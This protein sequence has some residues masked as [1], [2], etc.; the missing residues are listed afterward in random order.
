MPANGTDPVH[1]GAAERWGGWSWRGPRRG[2]HWRTCSYCGSIHPE[3]LAVEIQGENPPRPEWSDFKY[4]W[5]HK[6]YVR[7]IALR[8]TDMLRVFSFGNHASKREHPLPEGAVLT[9]DLTRA[10]RKIVK[11]CGYD[12]KADDSYYTF[13]AMG[14]G[15]AKHYSAHLAD[16]AVSADA[17]DAISAWQGLRLIFEDGRVQWSG[18]SD[19][20]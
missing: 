14:D 12:P 6:V 8:D 9:S 2:E 1:G 10:Q 11:A 17:V 18:S 13:G 19:T 3:D 5:P 4:G 7:G 20:E 15:W 16:P